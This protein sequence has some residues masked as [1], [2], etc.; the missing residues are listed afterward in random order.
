MREH[1]VVILLKPDQFLQV[2][3]LARAAN[4]KSMGA[5]V[6][7]QL[8]ATL[9]LEGAPSSGGG[10]QP[11]GSNAEVLEAVSQIKRLHSELKTF[12]AESL[13][14][15]SM[16]PQE[17]SAAAPEPEQPE[18][19]ES[20]SVATDPVAAPEAE[21]L[22]VLAENT[23]AISPRLG[24]IKPPEPLQQA[25]GRQASMPGTD[26]PGDRGSLF[27][28]HEVRRREHRYVHP[29]AASEV[30]DV[31]F[32]PAAAPG[33]HQVADPLERLLPADEPFKAISADDQKEE[34]DEEEFV[35]LSISER[36]RQLASQELAREMDDQ[37][38]SGAVQDSS[39]NEAEDE[40]GEPEARASTESGQPAVDPNLKPNTGNSSVRPPL[41][42][43]PPP[44]RPRV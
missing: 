34:E 28:R 42:G 26:E 1:Q 29:H 6:R 23:F 10:A 3:R 18:P 16:E 21:E 11:A 37:L 17:T 19:D 12:V 25:T 13:A 40:P 14:M 38:E 15:Y 22:E 31:P 36:R 9:G 27:A 5:F 44:K 30:L 2:Q 32:R 35:P 24:A 41:S 33:N 43:S 7:Q 4:A 8:L 39:G 20:P